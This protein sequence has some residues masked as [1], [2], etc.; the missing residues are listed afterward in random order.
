V[1]F[2][3]ALVG[4]DTVRNGLV[5]WA[6]RY[7]ALGWLLPTLFGAAGAGLAVY[8]VNSLAP[9]TTG[10]AIPHLKAVLY[11]LRSL[12][13]R[14][15]LPVEFFGGCARSG[16]GWH[17]DGRALACRWAVRLGL[18]WRNGSR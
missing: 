6:H 7:P 3:W 1:A 18:P 4:G 14:R 16:V 10:S 2:R 9:E 5:A 12:C 17:W 11:R 13:W 8:L 15:I